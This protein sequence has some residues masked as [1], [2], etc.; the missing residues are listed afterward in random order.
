MVQECFVLGSAFA[1][2]SSLQ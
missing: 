1:Q 2:Y